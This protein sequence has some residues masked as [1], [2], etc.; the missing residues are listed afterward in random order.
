[1]KLFPDI[2]RV[3]RLLNL[4]THSGI[5]PS[6]LRRRFKYFVLQ[7]APRPSKLRTVRLPLLVHIEV[8][9]V[10][11]IQLFIRIRDTRL[12]VKNADGMLPEI[13]LD[14]RSTFEACTEPST[15]LIEPA[16]PACGFGF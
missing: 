7:A 5:D 14:E 12:A 1:M 11:V 9:K 4:K 2:V 13:K 16:I 15:F 6:I 8:G 10:P 3:L